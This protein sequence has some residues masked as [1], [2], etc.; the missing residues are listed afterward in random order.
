MR[1]TALVLLSVTLSGCATII[2]GTYDEL[3]FGTNVDPVRVYIDG[4]SVGSTPLQTIVQKKAGN[5][6]MVRF[7]KAG[8]QTQEFALRNRLDPVAILDVTSILTSGGVDLITGALME[9][10]PKQYHI[11]MLEDN[12]EILTD[13]SKQIQFASFVLT[14][15]NSLKENLARGG[16]ESLDALLLQVKLGHSS[17]EFTKW[18]AD[19]TDAILATESPEALLV[20]IRSSGMTP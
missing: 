2:S 10:D 18:L 13:R 11:E 3:S 9:Y 20:I 5:N 12:E 15:A 1:F 19:N 4:L 14:F 17:F 16:G 7:E 6:R 8:Y